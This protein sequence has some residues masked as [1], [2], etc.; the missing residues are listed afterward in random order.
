MLQV[1]IK[2]IQVRII[3][4]ISEH[5]RHRKI[6]VPR[7]IVRRTAKKIRT[8][9][10]EDAHRVPLD[11]VKPAICIEVSRHS[12]MKRIVQDWEIRELNRRLRGRIT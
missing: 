6:A 12:G 1:D 11:H 7:V 8:R 10:P 4:K 9:V 2:N 5:R 3:V